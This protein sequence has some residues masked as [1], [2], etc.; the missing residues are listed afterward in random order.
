MTTIIFILEIIGTVAFSFSGAVTGIKKKLDIFGVCFLGV[1]TAVGG[2]IIRDVCLGNVPPMIFKN[3]IYVVIAF[4]CSAFIF[5]IIFF[6][7]NRY[8]TN[9]KI[10]TVITVFDSLGLGIFTVNGM[11]VVLLHSGDYNAFLV[12]F[13][14]LCTGIGGGILRDTL[15]NDIPIIFRKKVYALAGLIGSIPYYILYT[16]THI[17]YIFSMIFCVAVIVFFR[18]LSLKNQWNLPII[19]SET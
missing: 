3:Y 1:T 7:K 9:K 8:I 4:G 11:N 14:G 15:V 16:Q 19:D 12:V 6:T 5:F 17:H 10:D 18:L 2:G 13:V